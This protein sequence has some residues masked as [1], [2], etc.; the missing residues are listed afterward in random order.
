MT[1]SFFNVFFG[2][3]QSF[4]DGDISSYFFETPPV[5]QATKNDVA[6]EFVLVSAKELNDVTADPRLESFSICT[7]FSRYRKS[8]IIGIESEG[9]I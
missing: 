7:N 9:K 1:F 5:T 8:K 4:S 3:F 2:T 6:F